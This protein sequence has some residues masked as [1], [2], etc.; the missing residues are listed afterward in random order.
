[1][2]EPIPALSFSI[3]LNLER[4]TA[5]G[6]GVPTGSKPHRRHCGT[7]ISPDRDITAPQRDVAGLC[8]S[9]PTVLPGLAAIP[10]QNPG[11]SR[12][13]GEIRRETDC[14]L[15][16]RVRCELVSEFLESIKKGSLLKTRASWKNTGKFIDFAS[17]IRIFHW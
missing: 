13:Q 1:L 12:N 5:L 9:L 6:G 3:S 8:G 15:E 17:D 10:A 7:E 2:P 11:F 14:L 16:G 4:A